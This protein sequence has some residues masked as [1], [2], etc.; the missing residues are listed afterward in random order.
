MPK[1]ELAQAPSH[2]LNPNHISNGLG[3]RIL[4]PKNPKNPKPLNPKPLNP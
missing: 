3:A 4:N 1:P 2:T